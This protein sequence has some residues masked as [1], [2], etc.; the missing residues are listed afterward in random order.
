MHE[1][2]TETGEN[3]VQSISSE[4]MHEEETEK[5]TGDN[6]V[7]SM[8]SEDIHV[9]AGDEELRVAVVYLAVQCNVV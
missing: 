6:T 4:D 8:S 5:E 2:E 3:T 9:D 7:L 1:E